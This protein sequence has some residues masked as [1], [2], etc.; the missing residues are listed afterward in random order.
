MFLL[1]CFHGTVGQECMADGKLCDKHARCVVW[2]EEGECIREKRYMDKHCPASCSDAFA[3]YN[4]D[5][6]CQDVHEHCPLWAEIGECKT[7]GLSMNRYCPKSCGLCDK[8]QASCVD[9]SPKCSTW[10][11]RG[12]CEANAKV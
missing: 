7:N 5:G 2:K 8:E 9:T 12:E 4:R 6:K 11:A 1:L 3:E 10:A